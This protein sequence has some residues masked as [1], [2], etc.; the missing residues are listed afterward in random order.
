[1][2]NLVYVFFV[3]FSIALLQN[4]STVNSSA[5]SIEVSSKIS[6]SNSVSGSGHNSITTEYNGGASTYEIGNF[7]FQHNGGEII[8][9]EEHGAKFRKSQLSH[10]VARTFISTN[11]I[12]E[13]SKSVIDT[14]LDQIDKKG[15]LLFIKYTINNGEPLLLDYE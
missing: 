1:M 14:V 2:K 8:V 11:G 4:C 5:A 12:D 9:T 3:F 7:I 10:A 6:I 15:L 13:I